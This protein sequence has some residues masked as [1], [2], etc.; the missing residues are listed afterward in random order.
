MNAQI[1]KGVVFSPPS[2]QAEV[3]VP[4][5]SCNFLYMENVAIEYSF[6]CAGG[7]LLLIHI[8]NKFNY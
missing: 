4:L 5:L 3:G 6:R 1:E 8:F 7:S 2:T